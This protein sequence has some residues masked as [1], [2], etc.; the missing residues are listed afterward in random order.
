MENPKNIGDFVKELNKSSGLLK[1]LN[2]YLRKV[3][4]ALPNGSFSDLN[5][6]VS[7]LPNK[8]KDFFASLQNNQIW[9][10]FSI[11][12]EDLETL[13]EI[14]LEPETKTEIMK[15]F[16]MSNQGSVKVKKGE[17]VKKAKAFS[18]FK[19]I[20]GQDKISVSSFGRFIYNNFSSDALSN[21]DVD[22]IVDYVQPT[23]E[24]DKLQDWEF[25]DVCDRFEIISSKKFINFMVENTDFTK[26]EDGRLI[27]NIK[28]LAKKSLQYK[29]ELK[30]IEDE[31]EK[32]EKMDE[33]MKYVLNGN[34]P[35]QNF[36]KRWQRLRILRQRY[37]Q[38]LA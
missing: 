8:I 7:F 19:K 37:S 12:N 18:I 13:Y 2:M 25:W 6:F 9:K 23:G 27:S 35:Y 20:L 24:G 28:I 10:D 1:S 15:K 32:K 34:D 26:S 17:R 30:K 22:D 16:G 3:F 36:L 33:A 11:G 38:R 31:K 4:N 21:A 29:D 14:N 5:A